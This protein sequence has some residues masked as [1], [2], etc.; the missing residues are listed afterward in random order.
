MRHQRLVGGDNML[1]VVESNIEHL[2]GDTVGTADQFDDDVDLRIGRHCGRILVPAHGG[3]IDAAVAAAV[4]GGHRGDN[5][6][7][8]GALRQQIG[9]AIQQ[10]QCARADGAETGDGDPQRR[11]HDGD[12]DAVC[13]MR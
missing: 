7:A 10:L 6:P 5:K 3:Q 13:E 8:P 1:A 12:P 4:A 11:F 2:S 9:L